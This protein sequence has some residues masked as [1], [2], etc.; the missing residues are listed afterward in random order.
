MGVGDAVVENLARASGASRPSKRR[1]ALLVARSR[2][3]GKAH[4]RRSRPPLRAPR[5]TRR[6]GPWWRREEHRRA[7]GGRWLEMFK[8]VR[9][10]QAR[11]GSGSC[12]RRSCWDWSLASCILVAM[13]FRALGDH[14]RDR[15]DPDVQPGRARLRRR[16]LSHGDPCLR[17]VLGGQSRRPAI[18]QGTR[19]QGDGQRPPVRFGRRGNLVVG[20]RGVA[21]RRSTTWGA[22]R[23]FA[24]CG[25]TWA[26]W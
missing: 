13:M 5:D 2:E 26:S 1:L 6:P 14:R 15:R 3:S 8:P 24:T 9:G 12:R 18:G 17:L 25:P 20:A 16:R 21:S 4:R 7:A 10:P 22:S 23:N 19:A 11:A